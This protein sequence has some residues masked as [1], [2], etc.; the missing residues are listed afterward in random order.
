LKR[1]RKEGTTSHTS[2]RIN[3]KTLLDFDDKRRKKREKK[4]YRKLNDY[5]RLPAHYGNQLQRPPF[6]FISH[7]DERDKKLL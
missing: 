4:T 5:D 1:A 3:N 2:A 7:D 6:S